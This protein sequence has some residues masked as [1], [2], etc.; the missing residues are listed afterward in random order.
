M[1]IL[2]ADDDR[3]SRIALNA[4]LGNAGHEAVVAEDGDKAW[5]V[6]REGGVDIA[7]LDWMMPGLKGIELC[8]RIREQER[9]GRGYVYVM[10]LTGMDDRKDVVA[11]LEAGAD[12]YITKPFDRAVLMSRVDV[13]VRIKRYEARLREYSE[14]MERLVEERSRQLVHAERMATVGLL[15]AGIAHE[16]NNP[17]TFISGNIQTLERFWEDLGPLLG[18][19]DIG[20]EQVGRKVE[21]IVEQMPGIMDGMRKGVHKIS[22]IVDGLKGYCRTNGGNACAVDINECINSSLELCHNSLKY[23]V[24]VEKDLADDLP[25]VGADAQQME[26]VFVNLFVNAS[27]AID[28]SEEGL[29]EIR[30]YVKGCKVVV[31]VADNGSG[32]AEEHIDEIWKPFFTTKDVDKGTGLGLYTIMNIVRE[33][34][35]D[36]EAGNR[37]CGGA[38]FT[39]VLPVVC[40][41]G[42]ADKKDAE[43]EA[44]IVSCG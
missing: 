33:H 32:I 19:F 44:E 8:E 12:D 38:V 28:S 11:G 14:E 30:S 18:E 16:I 42:N 4:I 29:L 40:G 36:I 27:H 21:Y 9:E 31:E 39:V 2:V 5:D 10:L 35:G 20:D 7:I 41:K 26:Q 34:G 17:N 23:H 15:S 6:L 1:R 25:T 37:E 3:V 43:N 22:R 13:G 24:R